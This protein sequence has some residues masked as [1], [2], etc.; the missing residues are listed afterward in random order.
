MS[1]FTIKR[2]FWVV[3]SVD[4]LKE[5]EKIDKLIEI[6]EKLD[7]GKIINYVKL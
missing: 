4:I 2:S 3:P 5:Y 7:V 1:Y 6:L